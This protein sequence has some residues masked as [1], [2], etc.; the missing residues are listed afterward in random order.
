MLL[1]DDAPE[2]ARQIADFF[3]SKEEGEILSH[4]GLLPSCHPEVENK[5]PDEAPLM[6]LG[7]DFINKND[8]GELI[9]RVNKIFLEAGE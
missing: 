1:K 9:P 3:A 7:W 6:W 2:E 8:L 5:V 4:R